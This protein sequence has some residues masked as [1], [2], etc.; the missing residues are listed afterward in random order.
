MALAGCHFTPCSYRNSE[1]I[2]L[3]CHNYI[4]C[5]TSL[6]YRTEFTLMLIW[7]MFLELKVSKMHQWAHALTYRLC[8]WNYCHPHRAHYYAWNFGKQFQP[9]IEWSSR[10]V[11]GE[12]TLIWTT[13]YLAILFS[14]WQSKKTPKCVSINLTST[15]STAKGF[16]STFSSCPAI[17]KIRTFH[18]LCS[19]C[20]IWICKEAL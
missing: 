5:L 20:H 11:I 1:P 13:M 10:F 18:S 12:S 19:K 6:H 9:T 16:L 15:V 17:S 7:N 4:N 2:M 3:V 8:I 14:L